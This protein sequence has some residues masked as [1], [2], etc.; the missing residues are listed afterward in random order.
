[1]K[2]KLFLLTMLTI[3]FMP[4]IMFGQDLPPEVTIP[5]DPNEWFSFDRVE[6]LYGVLV[7]VGG[8][9]S[10]FIPGLKSISVGVYRVLTW[11]ILTGVGFILLGAP[12]WGVAI[13]YFLST[14]LYDIVLKLIIK[15][16]RPRDQNGREKSGKI[17][18]L[19]G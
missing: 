17:E 16:P 7:V 8:Y 2:F 12:I 10:A 9:L 14:G 15:S 6:W 5:T 19:I 18:P 11:G 1:M 13:T 4:M 3:M